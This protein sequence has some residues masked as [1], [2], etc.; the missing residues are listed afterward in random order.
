MSQFENTTIIKKAN[1]Y[2]KGKV[3]SHT[4]ILSNGERK[5]LGIML[6][7]NYTFSTGDKEIMEVLG[8]SMDVKLPNS[9]CFVTYGEGTSF[10]VEK[11]SSFDL[12]I[13]EV[14]D[15][16]CSYVKES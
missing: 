13:K 11:N 12:I 7:G 3:T 8:G 6:P 4:V 9:D 5:T 2:F 16:C 15:Y 10:E 14:S 1:V